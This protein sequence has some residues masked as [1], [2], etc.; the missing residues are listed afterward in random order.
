M[1]DR[2]ASWFTYILLALVALVGWYWWRIDPAKAF[3]IMLAVL[4]IS[5]PCALSLAAPAAFAAAGSHLVKR[6]V[7]L[8][9][10]HALETLARATHFVFD[11]T[12][13]L[14]LGKPML[15]RTVALGRHSPDDC[16]LLAG[17]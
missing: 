6:G 14:T 12:G 7:L 10:G 5:C 17:K 1:A 16:L 11:K 9:R 15:Q 8:T 3:E 4:V 2:L 13:T